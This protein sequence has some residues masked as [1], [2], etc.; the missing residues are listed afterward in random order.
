MDVESD[1]GKA[2]EIALRIH[3]LLRRLI[4][5]RFDLP[6][7]SAIVVAACRSASLGWFVDIAG[8]AY[9][10]Y[11]AREDKEPEREEDCVTTKE[12]AE[13]LWQEA[14]ER[15][16]GAAKD[17]TFLHNRDL[18]VLLYRWRD[19]A[20]DDGKEVKEWI[21][22]QLERNDGV[23]RLAK[24]FTSY[25]WSHGMGFDGLGDRVSRRNTTQ[26]PRECE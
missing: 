26:Y 10:D 6:A 19:I 13:K 17:G 1:R 20:A 23:V 4:L 2:F 16:R 7:R 14:L 9:R 18:P 21:G 15:I 12:D 24:G 3:W 5:E 25:S 11:H 8:S 22:D